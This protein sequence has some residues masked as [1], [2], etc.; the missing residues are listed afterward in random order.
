M[1]RIWQVDGIDCAS[2]EEAIERLNEPPV[3][4]EAEGAFLER[5]PDVWTEFRSFMAPMKGQEF[6]PDCSAHSMV[7]VLRHKGLVEVKRWEDEKTSFI[8]RVPATDA[9]AGGIAM[10]AG[11]ML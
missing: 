3:L 2:L 7:H 4:T 9:P 1:G 10:T 8:R 6:G 11:G 5:V